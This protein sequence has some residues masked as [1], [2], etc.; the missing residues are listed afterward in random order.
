MPCRANLVIYS[1]D[2]TDPVQKIKLDDEHYIVTITAQMINLVAKFR[3][4]FYT[5]FWADT[6]ENDIII[7][8]TY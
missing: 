1:P 5:H 7:N 2:T 8:F 3:G 4:Y 6:T